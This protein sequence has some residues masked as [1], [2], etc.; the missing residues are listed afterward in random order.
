M[1][2]WELKRT[3]PRLH[4]Y[5]PT[6]MAGL[7][8][9]IPFCKQRCVY[10]DF[11]FTTTRTEYGSFIDALCTE[12]AA[13]AERYSEPVETLYFGGGTPSLLS[14]D[15]L[16]RILTVVHHHFDTSAVEETTLELNPDEVDLDY[17]QALRSLGVDRLSIGIQSF[18]ESDLEFMNRSHTAE[19]A[20]QIIPMARKAGFENFSVDLIFG[21]PDQPEEHWKANLE[22]VARLEVPHL[23]TYGLTIEEKTPLGNRVQRGLVEPAS[24][25]EMAARYRFTMNYLRERG[26]EHYEISSFARPGLRARHNQRYWRHANY[27]GFGPSAHAFWWNGHG[28]A[29]RWANVANLRRYEALL[30]QRHLPLGEQETLDADA[31]ADEHV[32][33]RLRTADG[34]DL[35]H[36]HD[37]YG[38]DLRT[39]RAE[40]LDRLEAAGHLQMSG[41][42]V[43]LTDE[44]KLVADEVTAALLSA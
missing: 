29:R 8:L 35:E 21:L 28:S 22:K 4:P 44:G 12:L 13:Y 41:N 1:G 17:L 38:R 30:Q 19:E 42:T 15:E 33:L 37:R 18:F 3:P 27:L 23:S 26:Y 11:Y 9:H 20:E 36:L 32:M 40:T 10:C 39:Q 24:E 2:V 31:L 14:P 5:T 34:L 25:E 6:I 43:R 7:Y 16:E